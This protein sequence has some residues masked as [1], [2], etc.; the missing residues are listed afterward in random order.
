MTKLHLLLHFLIVCN[1]TK[2]TTENVDILSSNARGNST[3]YVFF[4]SGHQ[5]QMSKGRN[6][7]DDE[8]H[9]IDG[10]T[11]FRFKCY[12]DV[13]LISDDSGHVG[14]HEKRENL[15]KCVNNAFYILR[16]IIYE[17]TTTKVIKIHFVNVADTVLLYLLVIGMCCNRLSPLEVMGGWRLFS[18]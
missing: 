7:M 15:W 18:F 11:Q 17:M 9:F 13:I 14:K 3:R 1:Y 2:I 6:A 12:F 4:T 10:L 8:W 5:L 16:V